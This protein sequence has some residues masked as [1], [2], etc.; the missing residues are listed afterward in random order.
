MLPVRRPLLIVGTATL[1]TAH[2]VAP[3]LAQKKYDEGASDDEIR[4]GNTN[5]YSG[6]GS[7]YGAVGKTTEAYFRMI[8]EKGGIN[9]RKITFITYDDALS[10]PKTMELTR[11]LVESD[12]VLFIFNT[13]GTATNAAIH[14]YMNERKVPQLFVAAGNPKWGS[15]NDYPWTMG[16]LPDYAT[17]GVI[18]GKHILANVSDPT[19]AVL[20]QNDDLGR[21]YLAGLKQGLGKQADRI[22]RVATYEAA[23]PTVD[24]QIIQLKGSG[25]NTLVN[26]ATGKFAAQAIRK[27]GDLGWKPA[28]YLA[29]IAASVGSVLKP[30]GIENAQGIISAVAWKDPSDPQWREGPDFLGWKA[31]MEKYNPAGSLTQAENVYAYAVST[32]MVEVLKRCGD[33]LTRANVM[34]QAASLRQVELPMLLPGIKINTSPTD[35]YPIQAMHLQRFKGEA[36]ELFG[37][38]ISNEAASQ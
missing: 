26:I 8:N 4:I 29:G 27:A 21:D 34:R 3:A 38:I 9:G 1:L 20:M 31:F 28:H 23:D 17:E 19:I 24:T 7:S 13:L 5:P 25:A 35:F 14:N 2:A 10:P 6:P 37:D 36:W 12:K 11:K 33:D 22:V 18:Y 15:P 16:F 32:L 30:A